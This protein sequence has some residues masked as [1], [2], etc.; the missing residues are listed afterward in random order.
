MRILYVEDDPVAGEFIERGLKR[1]GLT[2]DLAATAEGGLEFALT[3]AY[4]VLVLDVM[5]PD[6]N[7]FDLLRRIRASGIE[8]PALFLSALAAV[9]DRV[10]GF[11]VGGDDY[12]PKPF[13]LVE[14]VARVKAL[15]RRRWST[16]P[17][18]K[19]HVGDLEMD[20]AARRVS[21]AGREIEF[22]PRQF[23]LLEY[24]MRN[25]DHALSRSMITENVWG[26]GF[27]SRSNAIDVQINYLRKKIDRD[28]D[29]KLLQTVKGVGYML[30]DRS[31]TSKTRERK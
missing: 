18:D 12:L 11:S 21:R 29:S 27:E 6:G 25:R 22:S 3:G 14:L 20:L 1:G 2:V 7:G 16:P 15:A 30:S 23:A 17:D 9:S 8:T 28:F 24:L 31:S 10:E 19:L 26:P 13:A 5:L 4:D